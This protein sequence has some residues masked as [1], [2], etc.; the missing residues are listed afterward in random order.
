[1]ST[2]S[3]KLSG[4]GVLVASVIG[5]VSIFMPWY[6][7]GTQ[8]LVPSTVSTGYILMVLGGIALIMGLIGMFKPHRAWGIVSLIMGLLFALVVYM[9]M[10]NTKELGEA[11]SLITTNTGYWLSLAGGGLIFLAGIWKTATR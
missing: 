11:A 9:N 1:M 5:L 3:Q 10:P 7:V 6:T 8:T 4:A 2:Q